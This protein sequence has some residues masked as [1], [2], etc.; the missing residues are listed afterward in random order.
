MSRLH[1][2]TLL[3]SIAVTASGMS[4]LMLAVEALVAPGDRVVVV[5]PL[6]PN[7]VEIPKILRPTSHCVPLVFSATGWTLDLDR[8]LAALTPDTRAAADQFAEQPDRLDALARRTAGD[9]RALPPTRHLDRRRRRLRAPLL[10]R[11]RMRA[12]VSRRGRADERVI[13]VNSFSKAWLMTGWRLGWLVAPPALMTDFGKLIEYN[14]SCSP[15]FVQRAGVAAIT[16]GEPTVARTQT[17]SRRPRAT[18]WSTRS[19]ACPTSRSHA[20]AGAMYAFFRIEGLRDS[21]A[22]CKALVREAHLGPCAGKRV[23]TGRRRLRALVLRVG[24]R[25]AGGGRRTAREVPRSEALMPFPRAATALLLCLAAVGAVAAD[26]SKTLRVAFPIA[27]NG[28]DPQAIYD[29]YSDAVCNAIFD[30]LYRYDYFARPVEARARTPPTACR[31]ITDGGRTFTIKVKPGIHFA[32][33][34]AFKGKKRELIAEDYVYSIKRM[35]RS[36][37]ALVRTSYLFE[38][39]LVGLDAPLARARKQ[40]HVRLRREDRGTAGARPLHA[41]HPLQA[42]RLRLP[43]VADDAAI[44]GGRARGRRGVSR[45]VRSR[46]GEPGRHR[47]LPAQVVDARPAD[48]PRSESRLSRRSAIPLRRTRD[49]G[50]RRDR[51]GLRRDASFRCVGNVEISI[52]EEAQP[53][54]LRFEPGQLDYLDRAAV[55]RVDR[56]RRRHGSSR[57]R[58][59]AASRCIGR[60]RAVARILLLQSG[61]SGRRRLHAGEDRAAPR[62]QRSPTTADSAIRLLQHGQAVPATQPVPPP[63]L[64]HDPQAR[65]DTAY[66]P[67]GGARVARPL[68]LQGPRWG[69]LSREPGRL[70]A[71]DRQGFDAGRRFARRRRA[72]EKERR[73]HRPSHDVPQEQVARAQQDG[74]SRTADDVG[75]G[76]DQR[77]PDGAPF[78]GYLYSRNIGTSNDARLRLAEY[79]RLYEQASALPDGPERTALFRRMTE[80]IVAYAPWIMASYRYYNVLA[81]PWLKAYKAN[82]FRRSQWAYYD[83]DGA[84]RP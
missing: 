42:A 10:R 78:Y 1:R 75:P 33:D 24:A 26:M 77:D 23:R 70:R 46:D 38:K 6:W 67:G 51:Q 47:S 43:V 35:L 73:R 31:E 4:A 22:F 20:P 71:H 32:A 44:R 76:M 69:R 49:A 50:R 68:R 8:L 3:D 80:L 48:R 64:G 11:R 63:L 30:P 28:F 2:P 84:T 34:P 61:R 83:V 72:V 53:R 82:P 9:P 18:S 58:Q 74:G 29:A 15:V 25:A 7:L 36:E 52:I 41:A 45:C 62:D 56:S 39:Q 14:T 13:S 55:A 19:R 60:R 16:R 40:R 65:A 17:R 21:L 27:E 54:L 66:D 59:D 37:G 57:L 81:Q 5:T 12:F 79:D